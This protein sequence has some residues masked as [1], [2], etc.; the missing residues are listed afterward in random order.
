MSCIGAYDN[1][2]I[3][4][5]SDNGS[6]YSPANGRLRG[7][8]GFVFEGGVRVPAFMHGPVLTRSMAVRAG[9]VS[10]ALGERRLFSC[11]FFILNSSKIVHFIRL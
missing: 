3:I 5:T 4:F 10:K 8:K 6:G 9:F 1:T 11:W 2:L 7:K